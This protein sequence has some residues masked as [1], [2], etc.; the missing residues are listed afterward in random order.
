MGAT[1]L[2]NVTLPEVVPC[3]TTS[4][5]EPAMLNANATAES[6]ATRRTARVHDVLMTIASLPFGT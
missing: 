4:G 2:V 1:S 5:T 6:L 3:A